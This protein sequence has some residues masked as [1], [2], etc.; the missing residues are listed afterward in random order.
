[1]MRRCRSGRGLLWGRSGAGDGAESVLCV[2]VRVLM[3][4]P[5]PR[6]QKAYASRLGRRS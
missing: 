1:M 6:L 4:L 2:L 5:V 3:V